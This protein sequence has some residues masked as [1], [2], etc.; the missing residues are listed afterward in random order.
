M[1]KGKTTL[2][3]IKKCLRAFD[4]FGESFTFKYKDED[5]HSTI[6][7]GLICIIFFAIAI[8]YFIYNFIP[9]ARNENFTLQY[10]TVN[11]NADR[12]I[13]LKD[14]PIAFGVGLTND[15]QNATYNIMDLFNIT[16]KFTYY[17]NKSDIIDLII[18][19]L[20]IYFA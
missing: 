18:L 17:Q 9:F 12:P 19:F 10:Y 13:N 8:S 5:K 2:R 20:K 4:F 11:S 15:N 1:E 16:I 3:P 7:G 14:D 6:L